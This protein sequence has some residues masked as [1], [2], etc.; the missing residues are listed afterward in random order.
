MKKL[1]I[2]FFSLLFSS[3][4]CAQVTLSPAKPGIS[5][6]ITLTFKAGEGNKG[7]SGHSGDVYMHTGLITDKSAQPTDWQFVPADWG[8]NLDK[9]KL[10]RTGTDTY[11][12][13][14]NIKDLYGAP[15][16]TDVKALVF[17]FRS[18]DG[19]KVGKATGDQ[20]VYVPLKDANFRAAPAVYAESRTP[21]PD[22]L[23]YA[24]VYEVNVRQY[25]PEGTFNAFGEHLPRLRDMGV[26]VL[27]FM[28]IHPIG[29]KDRKG[30]LGS[31]YAVQDYRGINPEY[32]NL[33]DFKRLVARA[34][35]MGMKVV[36]DWVANHTSRDHAWIAQH[37]TWYNYDDK[38]QIIAP[39]DW[40]D[41][42]DLNFDQ[43]YMRRAMIDDMLFWIK[44]A[45][46]DGFRCDVAG[47][48]AVDF[49][50]DATL[51]IRAV[52]PNV[53]MLAED[54]ASLWLLNNAF[55]TN[56]GWA[57]HHL[58]NKIAK[59]EEPA[60]AV[61]EQLEKTAR[62]YPQGTF[63]M[64]F[65]TNHDENSWQGTEYERLG[66]GVKAFSVLYY[67][68]PG[69]PL[70]Y[71]GQEAAFNR[72]LK[73]FEKDPIDWKDKPLVPFYTQLN[74][75]K[76]EN[77][78]LWNGRSGG[79]LKK[80]DHDQ[81]AFVAAYSRSKNENTVIT[82]V[83]LSGQRQQVELRVADAAGIY[84]EYFSNTPTTLTPRTK[85]TL[86]P[87]DYK[88]YVFEKKAPTDARGFKSMEKTDS[89]LRIRTNDGSLII[90]PHSDHAV[91]V[92]FEPTGDVNPPS[93]AVAT[94]TGKKKVR[95]EV[96]E[97]P[98]R[99]EYST[100]GLAVTVHKQPLRIE[101]RYKNRTILAE[102]AGFFDSGTFRGF[103]FHL[104]DTTEQLLG[105]GE[106]V[107]GMNRRGQRLRLYNK[108]SYGYETRADLMYYSL[109]VVV[110]SHKYM[111]VFDNGASGYLDLGAT[112]SNILQ[113]EAVGGRMAYLVVAADAWPDLAEQ[114]TELTGRQP[115]PPRWALG[116]IASRM[117]YHTQAQV[118]NTVAAYRRDDIPLDAVVLDLFWFGPDIK[119]HLGNFEW[120]RDSFPQPEAM[121][122]NFKKQGVKTVL[123]TEPF[124]LENTKT[125][126][127]TVQ[128][129]LLGKNAYG[130][131][132]L[133]DF[134]FGHTGLLDIFRPET[135]QWFWN[136]YKR[137]TNSGVDG[138]WGD[139]GEP[140][141]HPDD[142]LHANGRADH[143]HNLYGHV[144]AKTLFEGF[145]RDFPDRRPLILMRSGFVGSQRYGMIPWSGDVN[146]SWAGLQPQVEIAL[147][148][149]LQ[150]LGYMHSDLGGF[151]GDYK[152][153]E[154]YTRWLQYGVFQ[155]V[156]RTH[157]QESVPA[158]P[159]FWDEVTKAAARRSIQLRYQLLPYVYT[160]AWENHTKGLPM[161][162]PLFYL[163][164]APAHLGNTRTYLW[165]DAFLVSPVTEKGALT[166]TVD[167]PKG[168]TWVD[169]YT[170]QAYAGGQAL[171]V[172]VNM[173]HIPVYVR[174]G[175]FVPMAAPMHSTD[176][177]D[178]DKTTIHYYHHSDARAG[179]GQL[180][181]DD[182]AVPD[183]F[184]K[185]QF[186]LT[187]FTSSYSAGKL[188]L[189]HTSE[190]RGIPGKPKN[191]GYMYAVHGL[192]RMP[193]E[194]QATRENKLLGVVEGKW[195]DG[196]LFV[197]VD[198]R[199]DGLLIEQ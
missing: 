100:A 177:Y 32:G 125:Y 79:D 115:L 14:F 148:M 174:A 161:M 170:G 88:V 46:I 22:W 199:S 24:S 151:A 178:P 3:A 194:V 66:A 50:E 176:D 68:V 44:D 131:P 133:Y 33:E 114:Y 90:T 172:P 195:I 105:G 102:E 143:L 16:N 164:D 136:I 49:W 95:T 13:R 120:L 98:D 137:H 86:E 96:R 196:V 153:S 8:K 18:D 62:T 72:R 74:A 118:E 187:T 181:E 101:Y 85:M 28:P 23:R 75:L 48:V 61:F 159:V 45:D 156:F 154:L 11:Q 162:R 129:G 89:G 6:E 113:M 93:H 7:L 19:T 91:E 76:S 191:K 179:S 144:W 192:T 167:F 70:I 65:I 193:K 67:T 198:A 157:A 63:P 116:N 94:S 142:L 39:F 4:L 43:Y 69:M 145:Q 41:V 132:Y 99:I 82:V 12:I 73:F 25:T 124:V 56:Y 77:P 190:G 160:L 186:T 173:D 141:V 42:A 182:G 189:H 47:E 158:E 110:S 17:V 188:T 52:K 57:F 150:G 5:D 127:E 149:G 135:Q 107:L 108:A 123:I 184:S 51:A 166:Q 10:Q 81:P 27:W 119:G 197:P 9:L 84:R 117:G 97:L 64:Q 60:S 29:L 59:G 1:P 183:A 147:S 106:R 130:K 34:H 104:P 175:A 37:P 40:T 171:L 134:Y 80:I 146:R 31:Y 2:L 152:D 180:Y 122:A 21:E 20:D 126:D 78:A 163:D 87:W 58:M 140:E 54:A 168:A 30:L 165:G 185:K 155:P 53:W 128:K 111:L 55:N 121:M 83:N 35:G 139:L 92:A 169:F 36:I 112:Q 71:S 109:P 26:D 103:R 38:G 138:W 15:E